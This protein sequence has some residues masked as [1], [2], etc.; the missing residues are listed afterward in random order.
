M[1]F[2]LEA[3][4]TATQEAPPSNEMGSG[5][6]AAPGG[7]TAHSMRR[8]IEQLQIELKFKQTKIDA[9]AN[10][11]ARLR[12]WRFG[13]SSESLDASTQAVLFD[14]IV[15]DTRI[16]DEAQRAERERLAALL[17]A[18][19]PVPKPKPGRSVRSTLPPELPRIDHYHELTEP[20]CACGEPL[21]RIGEDTSEQLDCV[22][23]QFFVLRHHRGRGPSP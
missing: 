7:D 11:L 19:P 2:M 9:L 17:A 6:G 5:D 16:E 23:A 18:N 1:A 22:P 20:N 4:N 14:A 8:F 10:E 13:S 12:S 3:F 15:A 21:K